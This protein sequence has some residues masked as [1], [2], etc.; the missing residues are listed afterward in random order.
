MHHPHV[1]TCKTYVLSIKTF[2]NQCTRGLSYLATCFCG[3]VS[4]IKK[5]LLAFRLACTGKNS[6]KMIKQKCQDMLLHSSIVG[7]HKHLHIYIKKNFK[8][9]TIKQC[10]KDLMTYCLKST[11]K[12]FCKKYAEIQ[13]QVFIILELFL[14]LTYCF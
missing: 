2:Q 7:R 6:C 3:F 4:L 10:L 13:K 12:T 11:P 9:T 14:L 8:S 1:F 5:L